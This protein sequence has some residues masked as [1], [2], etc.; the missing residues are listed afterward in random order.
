MLVTL[1]K[2]NG[3]PG[4]FISLTFFA[5]YLVFAYFARPEPDI[6]NV[7]LMGGLVDHPFRFSDD[8]NRFLMACKV[9]LMPGRFI[10]EA[11]V[12]FFLL[13]GIEPRL[14]IA[15]SYHGDDYH[16]DDYHGDDGLDAGSALE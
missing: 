11:F 8:F 3:G 16:G 6:F 1:A 15:T 12:D 10:S 2:A 5:A 7:G 4:V 14:W 9:M 13:S